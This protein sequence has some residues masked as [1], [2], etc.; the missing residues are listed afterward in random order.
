MFISETNIFFHENWFRAGL[1]LLHTRTRKQDR[2]DE[3]MRIVL[4]HNVITW[5]HWQPKRVAWARTLVLA[6]STRSARWLVICQADRHLIGWQIGG[7]CKRGGLWETRCVR[8][9][10]WSLFSLECYNSAVS[11][12]FSRAVSRCV[13]A[14][15]CCIGWLTWQCCTEL[16]YGFSLNYFYGSVTHTAGRI[17]RTIFPGNS[18][19]QGHGSGNLSIAGGPCELH[20]QTLESE[21]VNLRVKYRTLHP[22]ALKT[23][24]SA[25]SLV[26]LMI[27]EKSYVTN[28]N[29]TGGGGELF[30][31]LSS[32]A[33]TSQDEPRKTGRITV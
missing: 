14:A 13:N 22:C 16:I 7:N 8:S 24:D 10:V 20:Q 6:C 23:K 4:K 12:T 3:P 1:R 28:D 27:K 32:L 19:I 18:F 17:T 25:K 26:C 11:L 29:G 21:Y 33:S 31:Q 5:E 9:Q 15:M 2:Y 30:Q